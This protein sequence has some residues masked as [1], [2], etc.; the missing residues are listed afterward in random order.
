AAPVQIIQRAPGIAVAVLGFLLFYVV[1]L[2]HAA[3]ALTGVGQFHFIPVAR[4]QAAAD[5]DGFEL[6]RAEHGAAAVGGEMI[7]VVGQHGGAIQIFSG[8][9]DAENSRVAIGDDLAQAIFGVARAEAP[10]LRGVAQLRLAV[11]DVEINRLRRSAVENDAVVAGGFE[12]GGPVAA[13]GAAAERVARE[14][15]QINGR[16]F[17]AAG[18]KTVAGERSGH[19]DDDVL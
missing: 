1:L 3:P 11:A 19:H 13:G 9:T 17:G 15:A 4:P 10:D 18:S 7:V 14:R 6:L 2:Q 8:R 5:D 12:I 16:H